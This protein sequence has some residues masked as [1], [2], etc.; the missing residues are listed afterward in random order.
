M[1]VWLIAT[2]ICWLYGVEMGIE[3]R[4]VCIP[5]SFFESIAEVFL[6]AY[7]IAERVRE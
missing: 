5:L 4:C 1:I 7:I 6:I 3:A 2:M